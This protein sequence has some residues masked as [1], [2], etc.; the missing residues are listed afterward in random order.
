[1][2]VLCVCVCVLDWFVM[3]RSIITTIEEQGPNKYPRITHETPHAIV[4]NNSITTT[5]VLHVQNA[6][7]WSDVLRA[8]LESL[9]A[10]SGSN[11]TN[12]T[13]LDICFACDAE[14]WKR[15]CNNI[16]LNKNIKSDDIDDALYVWQLIPLLQVSEYFGLKHI[17][18]RID[19][20]ITIY[21]TH[22]KIVN[23]GLGSVEC[24]W[25]L[26]WCMCYKSDGNSK[27][28]KHFFQKSILNEEYATLREIFEQVKQS[29]LLLALDFLHEWSLPL[30]TKLPKEMFS[31][32]TERFRWEESNVNAFKQALL[33]PK[34][35]IKYC[36]LSLP[37]SFETLPLYTKD[38]ANMIKSPYNSYDNKD[39]SNANSSNDNDGGHNRD[40]KHITNKSAYNIIPSL[41]AFEKA[42]S[43]EWD[44]CIDTKTFPWEHAFVAGGAV[45][46]HLMPC[47]QQLQSHNGDLDIFI[48]YGSD[49]TIRTRLRLVLEHLESQINKWWH[50]QETK[51]AETY[52]QNAPDTY[53]QE[54]FEHYMMNSLDECAM[55]N[56]MQDDPVNNDTIP[57]TNDTVNNI[58]DTTNDS[59]NDDADHIKN[60]ITDTV[61]DTCNTS[62]ST[63]DT[64][65]KTIQQIL[66]H[67]QTMM[68]DTLHD[69]SD[70]PC[71][72]YN[73]TEYNDTPF[74]HK[75]CLERQLHTTR[76]TIHK[77]CQV[78]YVVY[79]SLI[80]LCIRGINKT[81]QIIITNAISPVSI[82]G[83]FD[84]D[85]VRCFYQGSGH[86]YMLPSCVKSILT[87]KTNSLYYKKHRVWKALHKGFHV[88]Y[89][90][91]MNASMSMYNYKTLCQDSNIIQKNNN[92][93][94]IPLK[95]SHERTL[96]M[97][98]A[99]FTKE[100]GAQVFCNSRQVVGEI[101]LDKCGFSVYGNMFS[102]LLVR[103]YDLGE[104]DLQVP[105]LLFVLPASES[106]DNKKN[107]ITTSTT[108]TTNTINKYNSKQ[109]DKKEEP[110]KYLSLASEYH[111]ETPILQVTG[112]KAF[113][114]CTSMA[115][116]HIVSC[117]LDPNSAFFKNIETLVKLAETTHNL[118]VAKQL[119]LKQKHNRVFCTMDCNPDIP[120]GYLYH[121]IVIVKSPRHVRNSRTIGH[122]SQKKTNKPCIF[123][124]LK[125]KIFRAT[126]IYTSE[127]KRLCRDELS[128]DGFCA[129]FFIHM[130]RV[131]FG[132][133][134]NSLFAVSKMI[135]Y[136]KGQLNM[137]IT[138]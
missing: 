136:P 22:E 127:G 95:Q 87:G 46:K 110:L 106:D 57:D 115:D 100:T 42:F 24:I 84:M 56:V 6:R 15:I 98:N 64:N 102:D 47:N 114:I 17:S 12:L 123:H 118:F 44:F 2:V 20:I 119:N 129:K 16:L 51:Q 82:V 1:M 121:P 85:N 54:E 10:D 34:E 77:N 45:L 60:A 29:H 28:W 128:R 94:W 130:K 132:G 83:E 89:D 25:N 63:N 53:S 81:I 62:I 137:S 125:L 97:L 93:Y 76:T 7:E 39:K 134:N 65:S 105:P 19:Q 96:F 103:Y 80:T 68:E 21:D 67:V 131:F 35:H 108:T 50:K 122:Y 117:L 41:E 27:P 104:Q 133:V 48:F 101:K 36:C 18:N 111:F 55:D 13:S 31:V 73:N 78:Y 135:V 107:N 59:I 74:A 3:K 4:F 52:K 40:K 92:Y 66:N 70:H 8:R 126:R 86:V 11:E 120:N 23:K 90:K 37:L 69:S 58:I 79:R 5:C 33:E 116:H 32:M 99:I 30:I 72:D 49:Y 38:D 113:H 138:Q 91:E 26:L 14:E 61:I 124:N 71:N 112:T 75:K 43:S 109:L 9:C 88:L